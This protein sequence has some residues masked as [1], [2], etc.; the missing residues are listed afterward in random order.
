LFVAEVTGIFLPNR[1][2]YSSFLGIDMHPE[3]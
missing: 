2:R 1:H 3:L